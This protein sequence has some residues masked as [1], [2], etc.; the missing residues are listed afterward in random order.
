[1]GIVTVLI[2]RG[3]VANRGRSWAIE[4]GMSAFDGVPEGVE[5]VRAESE[6]VPVS[7][8]STHRGP[9]WSVPKSFDASST[10]LGQLGPRRKITPSASKGDDPVN[11]EGVSCSL[12]HETRPS[13]RR[14][15]P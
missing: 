1:M 10:D 2:A 6:G 13:C 12:A 11:P 9:S 7:A 14:H 15:Q 5:F 4:I 8:L 3:R